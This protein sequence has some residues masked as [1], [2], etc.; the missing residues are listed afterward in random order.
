MDFTSQRFLM[1]ASA[2]SVSYWLTKVDPASIGDYQAGWRNG[3]D[4]TTGDLYSSAYVWDNSTGSVVYSALTIK[5][6][7][8]GLVQ[9]VRVID[10][11][12]TSGILGQ[13]GIMR[14]DDAGY[15][16]LGYYNVSASN[17]QGM[18]YFYQLANGSTSSYR[19]IHTG[20][21]GQYTY[22]YSGDTATSNPDII[23]ISG[24]T[25]SSNS[26]VGRI[27]T[28]SATITSQAE[29]STVTSSYSRACRYDPSSGG[30]WLATE[31]S[32]TNNYV[33]ISFFNSVTLSLIRSTTITAGASNRNI[34]DDYAIC[35]NSSGNPVWAGKQQYLG[36]NAF[37]LAVSE[38]DGTTAGTS[39]RDACFKV[40]GSN[41][42]S[43][44]INRAYDIVADS[45]DNY[46]IVGELFDSSGSYGTAGYAMAY[47][48]KLNSSLTIQWVNVLYENSKSSRFSS[49]KLASDG[50]L[51]VTGHS[52]LSGLSLKLDPDG[53]GTGTYGVL[54]YSS[55]SL[56]TE[57]SV[58]G[59][60]S[61]GLSYGGGSDS[62]QT[63]SL[64][65][66]AKS[67][68]ETNYELT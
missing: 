7:K 31:W 18:F 27:D 60:S 41:T 3:L 12:G 63:L 26:W 53:G 50:S 15:I 4:S 25:H 13:S 48:L 33:E 59:Y 17:L 39:V 42:N 10:N 23:W 62:I 36:L 65:N 37:A 56:S 35:I 61:S 58:M 45:S 54:T 6:D 21:I 19:G 47:V 43:N 14:N 9:F 1:G 49:I 34:S 20:S 64:T 11:P 44:S 38:I 8:D 55:Y 22:A 67:H 51:M 2:G 52:S 57:T 68:T 24:L 46:Y 40:P 29:C 5:V 16:T 66:N 30:L 32:S 28:S